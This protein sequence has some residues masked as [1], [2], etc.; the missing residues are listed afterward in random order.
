MKIITKE[1]EIKEFKALLT[2]YILDNYNE[3]DMNRKRPAIIVFPGGAYAWN[4]KREAEGVAMRFTAQGFQAFVLNYTC[5]NEGAEYPVALSEA[6]CAIKWVRENA[7]ELHVDPKKIAIC[8]FSAG[9]HLAANVSCDFNNEEALLNFG[10]QKDMSRPNAC[11]LCY[12]VISSGEFAHKDSIKNLLGSR[13]SE[14]TKEKVSLE[15]QVS[16]LTP[17]TFIWHTFAD[18]S[19]PVENSLLYAM[20]LKANGVTCE[21]H[22]YPFG[23]HGLSLANSETNKGCTEHEYEEIRNWPE[24]AGRFLRQVMHLID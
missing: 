23:G 11:V 22:I 2:G 8:G 1:F 13:Y 17:P 16:P 5:C 19:V 24:L 21:M 18:G 7:A 15:N 14:E 12:P 6:L 4:S 9:G 20:S 10:G 3:I